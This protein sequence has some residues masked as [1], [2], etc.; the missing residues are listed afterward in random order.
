MKKTKRAYPQ[1]RPGAELILKSNCECSPRFTEGLAPGLFVLGNKAGLL[2]LSDYLVWIAEATPEKRAFP[3][4]D[5]DDHQHMDCCVPV[6]NQRLSDEIGFMIGL[7]S[8]RH[9]RRTL[10][11]CGVSKAKRITGS[12]IHHLLSHL[13]FI[14]ESCQMDKDIT[15]SVVRDLKSLGEKVGELLVRLK[16]QSVPGS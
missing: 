9:R 13:D 3:D 16:K 7:V 2:W 11:Y 10:A 4:C 14:E 15:P 5:P 8:M 1:K 12:P 6:V